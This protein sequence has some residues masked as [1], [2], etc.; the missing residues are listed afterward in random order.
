MVALQ[1]CNCVSWLLCLNYFQPVSTLGQHHLDLDAE[2]MLALITLLQ[3]NLLCPSNGMHGFTFVVTMTTL[4]AL[5][6]AYTKQLKRNLVL[7]ETYTKQFK[8]DLIL[9]VKSETSW[10]YKV[11]TRS[12]KLL[13]CRPALVLICHSGLASVYFQFR[14]GKLEHVLCRLRLS[15]VP[16][17][18]STFSQ[19]SHLLAMLAS[20]V[21]ISWLI[22]EVV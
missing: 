8:R 10:W 19:V 22:A 15:N 13:P 11:R 7:R 9:D 12:E 1:D 17:D 5:R 4:Q 3:H 20:A 2:A 21:L 6:E 16:L 18:V 14:K